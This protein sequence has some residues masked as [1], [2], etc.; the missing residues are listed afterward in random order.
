MAL[1]SLALGVSAHAERAYVT[2]N[3][4]KIVDDELGQVVGGIDLGKSV[5][6]DMAFSA[7]G[8]T[9]YLAHS[10]GIAVVDVDASTVSATWSDRAVND[11][12]L[13]EDGGLL[14]SLQHKSGEPYEVVAYA[15]A[16]GDVA[17]RHVVDHKALDLVV[18]GD[19]VLT[20][21]IGR[22]TVTPYDRVSGEA[23]T[24]VEISAGP[25][26]DELGTYI[27]KS[28]L[29]ADGSRIYV[30]LNGEAAGVVVLDPAT[31]TMVDRVELGHPAYVR[32]AVLSPDGTRLYLAALDHLSVIDL[33]A[34]SEIA[35]VDLGVTHQ[36]IDVTADGSK[37]FLV[38]PVFETAGTVAVVDTESFEVLARIDTPDISPYRVAV[39]P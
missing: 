28:L 33:V 7:D 2:S 19:R 8:K 18:T 13:D 3:Q 29:S 5:V 16:S 23:T 30:V 22:G 35:W 34:K 12:V 6:R 1:V 25:S 9:A 31:S 4:V 27:I 32:D 15:L 24:A 14:Y 21:N 36:G 26:T 39:L 17:H 38:N 37:L 11:L 10:H 20:T